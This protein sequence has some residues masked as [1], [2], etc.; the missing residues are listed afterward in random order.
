[1]RQATRIGR[2]VLTLLGMFAAIS[3]GRAQAQVVKLAELEANALRARGSFAADD[4][5]LAQARARIDVARSAYKP[6]F[7]LLGEA[8]AS[9]GSK[10][11]KFE[12]QGSNYLV[13]AASPLTNKNAF[14]PFPRF[15]VTFDAHSTL[16]DFGRTSAAVEAAES[17]RRAAEADADK[18]R[19][20]VRRDVRL[21]YVH[22]A[23]AQALWALARESAASAEQ[24]SAQT[25]ASIEEGARPTADR[26]ATETDAGFSQLELDRAGATLESARIDLGYMAVVELAPNAEPD[27][28]VL[29]DAPKDPAANSDDAPLRA[30][31][32]QRLAARAS[33]KVYDHAF[34][35]IISAQAL[36]GVQG[37]DVDVFP[38]YRLGLNVTVPLWN[39]GADSANRSQ[40]EAHAAELEAQAGEYRRQREYE[41]KRAQLV[42][43]QAQRRMG[44]ANHL[45]ELSNTRLAQLEEGYPLGAATLGQVADARAAV[46][47]AKTELVLAQA[48]RAEALLDVY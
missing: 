42:E 34:A 21:A 13:G 35:P 1:M 29:S 14:L 47:R 22:W 20:D 46:Q 43:A 25:G 23:S 28:S 36:A 40:A 24:R 26:I 11:V 10:L 31:E 30:L 18:S 3:G 44:L 16:Y 2:V 38:L 15:A 6:S 41:R 48:M 12:Y 45:I 17:Q 27:P 37:Q 7:N 32:Q 19:H 9:P 8:S 33:A 39:G 5:R 4:A